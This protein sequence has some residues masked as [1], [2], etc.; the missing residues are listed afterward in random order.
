MI[1]EDKLHEILM[2]SFEAMYTFILIDEKGYVVYL[3]ENYAELL[4]VSKEEA[5]GKNVKDII[6]NTRLDVVMKTKK[7]E[8]GA[9]MDFYNHKSKTEISLVCNR[10]PIIEN[11][12]VIGA[13]GATTFSNIND[14][15]FLYDEIENLKRSNECYKSQ[16][17]ELRKAKY[18]IDQIYGS[19]PKI[20]KLKNLISQIADSSLAVLITGE[21]GTGKEVFANA[22]HELSSRRDNNFVKINCA[23]IP[24]DLLESELFGYAEGAFTGALKNG[25]IG[26]F[27][28]A[29]NGTILLDEIGEL[30]M[31]LQSKLLRVI[32]E[33]EVER[34]GG[35][36]PI[37]LNVRIICN[38]NKNIEELVA[39]GLFRED[40]YYRINVVELSIPPLRERISDLSV[41][42]NHFIEK[43]NN[44]N[45]LH[46][47]GIDK[48]VLK[49]FKQYKWKG[50]IRELEHTLERACVMAQSGVI[51]LNDFDF[52][53]PRIMKENSDDTS[54]TINNDNKVMSLERA[55][56]I[57][58]K[59]E[60]IKALV[61]TN[62]NKT[63]AAILLGINRTSLYDKLKKH[64]ITT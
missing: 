63:K 11:N 47:T 49:L 10:I 38:T 43:I 34:V 33:K 46:I 64:N 62:G 20:E 28:L 18:S 2:Q 60:I 3:N 4:G 31:V 41:L 21:T 58:E 42:C 6:P 53:M 32:Q 39:K 61:K 16:I 59:E 29:N 8:I 7:Q 13:L 5:I 24:K 40:L 54:S 23:A 44:E 26:K 12:K 25:K 27:E 19:C 50:N 36:K 56:D 17:S 52:L 57:K 15:K 1:K 37:K 35:V 22:I 55:K 14:V 30:P 9:I 45:G 48:D 51:T